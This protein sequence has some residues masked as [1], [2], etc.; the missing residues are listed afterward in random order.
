L[1]YLPKWTW[2]RASLMWMVCFQGVLLQEALCA[3]LEAWL[4]RPRTWQDLGAW[5]EKEFLYDR[6]RLRDAAHWSRGMRVQAPETTFSRKMGV[7]A[8]AALLCKYALNRMDQTYSA[9]VVYLDHGEDKLPHYVCAFRIKGSLHVMD[10]G[11]EVE[12][13]RGTFGPFEELEH[14]VQWYCSR[15]RSGPLRSFGFGWIGA[16]PARR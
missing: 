13:T 6:E 2:F 14:Y 9:Q 8:D 10:Y 1:L 11:T 5:F 3:E 15:T 4:S 16:K 12:A 7:C